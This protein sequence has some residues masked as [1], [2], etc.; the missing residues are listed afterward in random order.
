[1][2]QALLNFVAA[3]EA[4]RATT[5]TPAPIVRPT[6]MNRPPPGGWTE[7][8]KVP[9]KEPAPA[10]AVQ[11]EPMPQH[12]RALVAEVIEAAQDFEFYPTTQEII[13]ALARD[14]C[15]VSS[16][17]YR[18]EYN[19]ILDIGAGNGKVLLALRDYFTGDEVKNKFGNDA[20]RIRFNALHAIEKSQV[21]CQQLDPSILIVG[22]EFEEQSLLS[23]AVD[24]IFCNPPYSQYEAWTEKIIRQ[25][26]SR[27]VYLVIPERWEK[28]V[29]I[30]D[31]IK[32]REAEAHKVGSFDFENAE[33]RTARAKVHLL[34]IKLHTNKEGDAFE[35]FFNEQ[36]ADLIAKFAAGKAKPAEDGEE[37]RDEPTKGGR[38]RPFSSLV[39]GPNYPEALTGLYRAEMAHVE[40]NY[41][42]V[43]EL[44]VDLLREFDISPPRIMACLKTRLAGLRSAYWHELFSHLNSVTDRL[45]S[46]SRQNLLNVLHKHVEVDF[47]VSNICA[48]LVWVIKNANQYI[49]SQLLHTYELMVD[50]CNV[51][52]YKSNK[53][54]WTDQQWRYCRDDE[55]KPSH[56]ALDYRIVTHRI[57]GI[58]TGY[59]FDRGL[60]ERGQT[61]LG[62]L[63]TIAKNLGFNCTTNDG[64]LSYHKREEW[65]AGQAQQFYFIHKKTNARVQLFDVRAFKNGN[66]HLRLNQSFIL[67]LNVEHGR[68]RGWLRSPE[69]AVAELGEPKAAAYFKSNLQLAPG[70]GL[71]LLK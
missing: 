25:A 29:K 46:Q 42:L 67:A 32:F 65:E 33:D 2:S 10:L 13:R 54:T 18:E 24:V 34:R 45:T 8:D 1:M 44:D 6:M 64:R 17:N 37:D 53:R 35:R 11:P 23:K 14:L 27:L 5:P 60:E 19:S 20:F 58:K 4:V 66:L 50:K 36:F 51:H 15:G 9:R 3:V 26:A 56:F 21:L 7:A 39:V 41:A 57:G 30:A 28:S 47:T 68:L 69:E 49:D 59:S 61:F 38:H 71:L 62:D 52:L 12:A 40:K 48:V 55:E 70:S 16:E 63:L 22:T 31:A 43:S